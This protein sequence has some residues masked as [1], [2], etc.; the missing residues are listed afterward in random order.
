MSAEKVYLTRPQARRFMVAHQGLR[1]PRA[2]EGKEGVLAYLN[3]VRCIQYDPLDVVGRN[4]ELVLQSRVLNFRPGMLDELLYADRRL[5]DAWDKN[6]SIYPVEDWPYFRRH[7]EAIRRSLDRRAKETMEI[8]PDVRQALTERGPL[9]SLDLDM[10][11]Q[12]K[13]PWAPTR[14]A[15]AALESMYSWGELIVHHKVHTRKV[16]D[17]AHNHLPGKLLDAP[18]PNTTEEAYHDWYMLRRIGSIG[19]LWNRSGDAWLGAPHGIKSKARA[20]AIERLRARGELL[21]VEVEDVAPPLYL[22]SAD[23]PTLERVLRA[24]DAAP[25]A[26]FLAP[27]DN[28]IWDRRLTE[29]L[30]DFSYVWEVY[31]PV[32]ERRYGYYVLPV[33]YDDRFVARF[34]PA[35]DKERSTLIVKQWWWEPGIEVTPEM[36]D[37]LRDAMARFLDYLELDEVQIADATRS[38]PEMEW[39]E[40]FIG[41]EQ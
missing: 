29:A 30:F 39:L 18:E 27:L 16:Y 17:F 25:H 38:V 23:A 35:R 14:I 2:L 32:V 33:L 3:R 34:E 36:R 4:P 24:E 9:S 13:W 26:A 20:A 11:Q 6:M 28:L 19:L 12:V 15:R 21:E 10:D 41:G 31:K 37:A 5:V 7:R 8:L 1:S 40:T 22:R